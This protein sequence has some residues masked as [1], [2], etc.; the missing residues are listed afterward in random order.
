MA[1][2]GDAGAIRASDSDRSRVQTILNDAFAEGRLT[3]EEWDD[4]ATA[5]AGP[6]THADLTRLTSDLV[7]PPVPVSPYQPPMAAQPGTNG[8]AIASLACGIGQIVGGPFAGIAA[9]VLGHQARRRI[10]QTGE[11]GDGLA[12]AGLVLGYIGTVG[13]VLL[14]VLGLAFVTVASVHHG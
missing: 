8:M 7:R 11:Q 10:R 6:V 12:V 4:R 1:A 13:L 5:L 2:G 9:I 3:R 14:L